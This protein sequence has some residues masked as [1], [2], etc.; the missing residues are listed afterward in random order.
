[1]YEFVKNYPK[2]VLEP[3]LLDTVKVKYY[4][5]QQLSIWL[6]TFRKDWS[7]ASPKVYLEKL[8]VDN[9]IIKNVRNVV[10][11]FRR[12]MKEKEGDKLA[13]WCDKVISDDDENIKGFAKGILNDFQA[14]YRGFISSW[15]NGLVEAAAAAGQVN[16]LKNIKRQMYG[17]AGFELLRRRVV[18]MSQS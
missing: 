5:L 2:T 7:E 6:S 10:L 8:L 17:R 12:L 16:R 4:S 11:D 15:S 9:P 18:I 14:D 3:L 1:M 13:A